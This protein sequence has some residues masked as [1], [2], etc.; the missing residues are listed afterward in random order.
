MQATRIPPQRPIC[1]LPRG[2]ALLLLCVF[3]SARGL[4]PAGFM[5]APLSAGAPYDL[6]HGDSRS[7]ELLNWLADRRDNHR[8]GHQHDTLTAQSFADNHCNFSAGAIL[9]AAPIA[10]IPPAIAGVREPIPALPA[11]PARH[12]HYTRPPG[13]APPFLPDS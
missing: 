1:R 9:A 10:E 7:L 12:R 2:L 6:C 13:R 5:P 4:V 3:L 8:P 11:P